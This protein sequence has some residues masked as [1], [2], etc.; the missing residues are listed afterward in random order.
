MG[1]G[2]F[3]DSTGEQLAAGQSALDREPEG[4]FDVTEAGAYSGWDGT[5][6]CDP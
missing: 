6:V 1:R 5:V 3:H 4:P 2:V